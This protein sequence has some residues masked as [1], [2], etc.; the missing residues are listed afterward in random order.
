MGA[1][2][3]SIFIALACL[4]IVATVVWSGHAAG[5]AEATDAKSDPNRFAG[6]FL[7]I[8]TDRN[9]DE[10]GA[11]LKDVRVETIGGESFLVGQGI[12]ITPEW[13]N[14]EGRK[15]WVSVHHIE[16]MYEFTSVDDIKK[17]YE[18]D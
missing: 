9:L 11:Y 6:K 5:Q 17:M 18:K 12:A 16:T 14:Y 15:I 2:R 8:R 3:K 13:K 10:R 1:A 4:A 7:I